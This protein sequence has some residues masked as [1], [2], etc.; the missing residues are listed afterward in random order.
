MLGLEAKHQ[1]M[2]VLKQHILLQRFRGVLP[3]ETET[4][5]AENITNKKSD[6]LGQCTSQPSSRRR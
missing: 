5:L 1:G 4:T 2:D 3:K 6:L